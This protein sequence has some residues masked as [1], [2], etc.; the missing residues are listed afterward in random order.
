MHQDEGIGRVSDHR[1]K[2][3]AGMGRSFVESTLAD[4]EAGYAANG[5]LAFRAVAGS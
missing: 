3:F 2:N 1:L 4:E 5:T